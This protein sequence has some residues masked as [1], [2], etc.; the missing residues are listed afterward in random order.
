MKEQPKLASII[1]KVAPVTKEGFN[2]KSSDAKEVEGANK[3]VFIVVWEQ[4]QGDMALLLNIQRDSMI[5][6]D[7]TAAL[8]SF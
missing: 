1:E 7:P 5:L 6:P 3:V 4:S 8:H 2:L